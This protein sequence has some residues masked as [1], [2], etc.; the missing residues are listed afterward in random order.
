[1][2]NYIFFAGAVYLSRLRYRSDSRAPPP[3]IGTLP[4]HSYLEGPSRNGG[5]SVS[6]N[7][8]MVKPN[9]CS[10][11]FERRFAITKAQHWT[12]MPHSHLRGTDSGVANR[13]SDHANR[14]CTL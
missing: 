9:I 10:L 2:L 13:S 14:V 5:Q 6:M 11:V 3:P 7:K 12:Y 1:M 8:L 4:F